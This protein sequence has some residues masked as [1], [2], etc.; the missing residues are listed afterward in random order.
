MIGCV[1]VRA[2]E[3]QFI[4]AKSELL[5]CYQ[6]AFRGRFHPIDFGTEHLGRSVVQKTAARHSNLVEARSFAYVRS[7]ARPIRFR[8][9]GHNALRP[10]L[11]AL[12]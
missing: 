5:I 9:S 8:W 6:N 10:I 3:R 11:G 1:I 4:C 7:D 12:S 2:H